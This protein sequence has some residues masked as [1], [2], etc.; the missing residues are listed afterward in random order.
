MLTDWDYTEVQD[1]EAL[2]RIWKN[3]DGCDVR[4]NSAEHGARLQK[5]LGLPIVELDAAQSAFFK[6]HYVKAQRNVGAM[7]TEIDVIRK[8]EGW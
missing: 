2:D 1:F 6:S 8:L 4:A 7:V 5:R 3:V